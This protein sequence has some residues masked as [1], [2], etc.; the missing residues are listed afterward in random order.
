MAERD[1]MAH[2]SMKVA[3]EKTKGHY[4]GT[5]KRPTSF[6]KTRIGARI[7]PYK[8]VKVIGQSVGLTSNNKTSIIN[9]LK[10]GLPISSFTKLQKIMD[11]PAG[12]LA[13]TVNIAPRT[14]SRR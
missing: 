4:A 13:S 2:G 9:A 10:S 3:A 8:H 6:L 14:L 11:V 1:Q 7:N 12:E 5:G